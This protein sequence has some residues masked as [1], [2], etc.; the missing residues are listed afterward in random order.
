[1]A[2]IPFVKA[3]GDHPAYFPDRHKQTSPAHVNLYAF[4]DHL[5][6]FERHLRGP[7][8][9]E[10]IS[11][12]APVV[13]LPPPGFD[14]TSI[15]T[16]RNG[17][18]AFYKNGNDPNK[19]RRLW[20]ENLPANV[21]AL[22]NATAEELRCGLSVQ[23]DV[24]AI[25]SVIDRTLRAMDMSP[26]LPLDLH[27]FLTAQLDDYA[28]RE[29]STLLGRILAKY[30]VDIYGDF[31]EHVDFSGSPATW[32]GSGT[33]QQ[34][35]DSTA[36]YLA[37]IDMSPNTVGAVHERVCHAAT[38]H[39]LCLTNATPFLSD[40]FPEM[41]P[42]AFA[43]NEESVSDAIEKTL[44]HPREA[45]DAGFAA[46]ATFARNFPEEH[47]V[48][49]VITAADLAHARLTR[50]FVQDFCIWPSTDLSNS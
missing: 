29:K 47:L 34:M 17:R 8:M 13:G 38:Y 22:L 46:A 43:F 26:L 6:F 39:T 23:S 20:Q 48:N 14:K 27:C 21:A 30:P 44:A 3:L 19:L 7:T 31:W 11:G 36:D 40:Y 1:M 9:S 5:D 32:R 33:Y 28:R 4:P 42:Y 24:R 25:E 2:G 18:L 15:S 49:A 16:Q 50:P 35:I 41:A 12:H 37:L 10:G 45:V